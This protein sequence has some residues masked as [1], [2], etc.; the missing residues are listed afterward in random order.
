MN[1]QFRRT[2]I[3]SVMA[4]SA[5]GA[6]SQSDS[7][8]NAS[9]DNH[10][11]GMVMATAATSGTVIP[12]YVEDFRL[13]DHEGESHQL[14]YHAD[15][16]A[17]VIMTQ[18][19]GC[20]IVR[21]AVPD[22][23]ALRDKYAGTG[24]QFLMM[25]SNMQ[26]SRAEI[27]AEAE[28]FGIDMPILHDVNQI[29]GQSMGVDRTAQVFVLDPAQGFKV[30]YYGPLN[31]R[32]TYERQRAEAKETYVDDVLTAVMAG[33]DVAVASPAIRAGCMINF[34]VRKKR[35]EIA[36]LSYVSD[37][38]PILKDNCVACHQ[39]GGIG[40]WAMS[41]YETIE[42]WAPMMRQVI[43]TD[44][45]PPWHADSEIGAFHDDRSLSPEETTT[46]INWIEAG[47]KRG[48]GEDP[49]AK[50]N[51]H[52]ED[53]PLGEPDLLLT[54]PAHTVPANGIVDYVYPVV[55]NP[56]TEDRWLKSTT[57]KA[58]NRQVVHHVLSGYMSEMPEDARGSTSR[59][60]FSTGGYAV[61]AE[62]NIHA[63]NA[64]VPFPAGGAIGFQ[65]H[66]TPYGKEVVDETQIG[67]YFHDEQPELL[68]R[69][70]VIIDASIEIPAG[71]ARHKE[72]AYVE[73]P[74]DA[75]LLAAFP[76]AHY[77]GHA[78]NLRI[79]YPDGTEEMLLSLPRYDFN[80]QRTY[81]FETPIEVPAGSR[82]IADYIYDNSTANVSNPDADAK[83][84]WGEQSHE[85]M[86]FTS[87]SY[88]WKGETTAN[89]LDEQETRLRESRMLTAMDDNMDGQVTQDEMKGMLGA[90]LKP[91]FERMDLDSDGALTIDE[92]LTVR[93][94]MSRSS[95]S[96]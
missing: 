87:L 57:I 37:I 35:E 2:L 66:Y 16:P 90:R 15:A 78:S 22:Y 43:R 44:R 64:G 62:S 63:D 14:F 11:P 73:F 25:N 18:G 50:L 38:A 86:L 45:M 92:W 36:S 34:P 31:D 88:R 65:M 5:L 79:R 83:V 40:P 26:D 7:N 4:C 46:L 47:A 20:P 42:G 32:Q 91:S 70:T 58:G 24:V 52:A 23:L 85:E 12:E 49:L 74:Y 56:L 89:R 27:A 13:I 55:A 96:R 19:N 67:F 9:H 61:G 80:W 1:T 71:A 54:L 82:L 41:D 17:V 39:E 84:T 93:K 3:A 53:W 94:F 51:L 30:V 10:A 81:A 68:D 76:H 33:E 77:R 8:E 69:S 29:I 72:T 60:E 75:E 48:E 95:G 59:W 28:E 6:C 21:G